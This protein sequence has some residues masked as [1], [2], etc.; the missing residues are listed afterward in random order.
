[1][2]DPD[3]VRE[4][5][6]R[7]RRAQAALHAVEGLIDDRVKVYM[8]RIVQSQRSHKATHD[9]YVSAVAQIGA[10]WDLAAKLRRERD[11]GNLANEE[12]ET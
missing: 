12:L 7:G 5:I 8:E 1:M 3:D 4:K 11:Q 6:E 10:L 2:A 9:E